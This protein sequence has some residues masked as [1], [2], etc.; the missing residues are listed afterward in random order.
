[1]VTPEHSLRFSFQ[2]KVLVPVLTV[3]VLL[4]AITLWV[5]TRSM[6]NQVKLE[7]RQSLV[8]AET[9]FQQLLE[10]RARDLLLRFRNAVNESSYRSLAGHSRLR[11]RRTGR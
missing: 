1:M 7:A 3:L 5:V 6:T 10:L 8:T 2:T 4:P 9:F 11:S